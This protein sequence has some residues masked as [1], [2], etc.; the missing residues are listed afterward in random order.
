MTKGH[1]P[2]HLVR[3]RVRLAGIRLGGARHG[4]N[5]PALPEL[6]VEGVGATQH[7]QAWQ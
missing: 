4:A 1:E 5:L 6:A 2:L 7:D 3:T